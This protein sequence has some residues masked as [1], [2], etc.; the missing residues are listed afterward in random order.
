M[1]ILCEHGKKIVHDVDNSPNYFEKRYKMIC[2]IQELL[3]EV[4]VT[5]KLLAVWESE[6]IR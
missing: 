6:G 5:G 4:A 3:K 2:Q 1:G